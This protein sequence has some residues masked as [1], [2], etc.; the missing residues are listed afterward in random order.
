MKYYIL[1]LYILLLL[2]PFANSQDNFG[3]EFDTNDMKY[4]NLVS[5]LSNLYSKYYENHHKDSI[6]TLIEYWDSLPNH[7]FN[8]VRCMFAMYPG[9]NYFAGEPL[10]RI[11]VL[12]ALDSKPS[13]YLDNNINNS[14]LVMALI[15]FK[16]RSQFVQYFQTGRTFEKIFEPIREDCDYIPPDSTFDKTTAA[17]AKSLTSNFPEGDSR[18]LICEVYSD[19]HEP[20]YSTMSKEEYEGSHLKEAYYAYVDSLR[21]GFHISVLHGRWMP[22]GNLSMLGNHPETGFRLGVIKRDWEYNFVFVNRSGKSENSYPI[23]SK[24]NDYY[25]RNFSSYFGGLDGKY[26]ITNLNRVQFNLLFGLGV[27]SFNIDNSGMNHKEIEDLED[28]Y[29]RLGLNIGIGLQLFFSNKVALGIDLIYHP[30]DF[31]SYDYLRTT[32]QAISLQFSLS[33]YGFMVPE[34]LGHNLHD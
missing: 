21:Y 6:Q 13:T 15:Q 8:A 10:Y 26:I 1:S 32:G 25:G 12:D 11:K 27:E 16:N 14:E 17:Y 23:Y 30:R 3:Y 4:E 19:M 2:P 29:T 9:D 28:N 18:K 20:L 5:T 7:K 31:S 24:E 33:R 34:F 22:Q